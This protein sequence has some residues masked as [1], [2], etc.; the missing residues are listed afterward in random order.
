MY[1]ELTKTNM[2][3]QL[4][5]IDTQVWTKGDIGAFARMLNSYRF[6]EKERQTQI[7]ELWSKLEDRASDEPY[8]ITDEQS[9]V[10]IEWLRKVCFTSKGANRASKEVADFNERE[11]N[12]V[13]NFSHFEFVGFDESSNGYSSHYAPIYRTLDKDGNYFDYVARMWQAPQILATGKKPNAL[14]KL[15]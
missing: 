3:K 15:L 13:R 4:Q 1:K 7:M 9:Q 14:E 8:S 12:I 10:G 11:F 6:S 2:K 5:R